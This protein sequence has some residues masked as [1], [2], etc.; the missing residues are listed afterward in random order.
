MKLNFVYIELRFEF[1]YLFTICSFIV[2]EQNY[3]NI[4][5]L[6]FVHDV[7]VGCL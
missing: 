6:S 2:Y 7:L 3:A 4:V 5:Q 1:D